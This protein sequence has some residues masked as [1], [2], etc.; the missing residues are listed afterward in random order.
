MKL[1][2]EGNGI[3]IGN[4]HQRIDINFHNPKVVQGH[5][6]KVGYGNGNCIY[7]DILNNDGKL[8][9]F[10]NDLEQVRHMR[11]ELERIEHKLKPEDI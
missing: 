11:E 9:L 10:F 6:E 5:H 2:L 8:H 7:L 4:Y 1:R 3:S